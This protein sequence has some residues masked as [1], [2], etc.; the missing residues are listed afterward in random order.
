VK[1]HSTV[2]TDN[3]HLDAKIA[4]RRWALDARGWTSVSVLDLCAGAGYIWSAMREHVTVTDYLSVDKV[5]RMATTIKAEAVDAARSLDVS[6][7]DVIDIDTYGEPWEI[8]FAL[9]PRLRRRP[10]VVYLTCGQLGQS[11]SPSLATMRLAGIPRAWGYVPHQ[12]ELVAWLNAQAPSHLWATHT[13]KR[14]GRIV[15]PRVTYQA[16]LL[17]PL[18]LS[19]TRIPRGPASARID[20]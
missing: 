17:D 18:S 4:L 3:A 9:A 19:I 8:L 11:I 1:H 20:A 13:I 14:A 15:F 7:F 6:R 5:P 12:R 10:V 2:K 16:L